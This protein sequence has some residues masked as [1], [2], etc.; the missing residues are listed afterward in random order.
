MDNN[1]V[2]IEA[3]L[4][5]IPFL[6]TPY[7]INANTVS[8]TMSSGGRLVQLQ[9]IYLA[10]CSMSQGAYVS[11][12][13]TV[14]RVRAPTAFRPGV[15]LH[16]PW[17]HQRLVPAASHR[18]PYVVYRNAPQRYTVKHYGPATTRN[19]FAA[20]WKS[21]ARLPSLSPAQSYEFVRSA[22]AP[23]SVHSDGGTGAIHT[24]PAP[25]LSLS[26]KPIV[27]IDSDNYHKPTTE[28]AKPTY[29]VTEKYLEQPMYDMS[30]KIEIPVGFSKPT[31]LSPSDIQTLVK[32]GPA[33][34]FAH[35]Y[36]LSVALPSPIA[37][38]QFSLQGFH[39]LPAHQEIMNPSLD[40]L[41][42]SPS[43]LY[44]ADPAF[45][46]KL[47]TQL[48]QRFP[49]LGFIPYAPDAP[50]ISLQ[51]HTEPQIQ[52]PV[53]NPYFLL[54][55]EE[56]TKRTPA[57]FEPPKNVVQRETHESSVMSLIPHSFT[58]NNVTENQIEVTSASEPQNVTVEVIAADSQ[59]STTTVKYIVESTTRQEPQQNVTPIYYAQIGQSIGNA[60]AN[61]FYSAIND[62]RAAAALAQVDKPQEQDNVTSTTLNPEYKTFIIKQPDNSNNQSIELKPT[63]LGLP[64]SK[65][66]DSVNIAY[67]LL[68]SNNKEP[69]LSKEGAVYGGQI[70]EATISEDKEYNKEKATLLT[71]RAPLRI[72]SVTEKKEGPSIST[73]PPKITVVKAKIPPK[74]KLTFDDKTGE[75]VLRIYASYVDTPS[76]KEIVTSKL[77]HVNNQN[78]VKEIVVKKPDT[79]ENWTSAMVKKFDKTQGHDANQVTDFGLKLRSRSD[80]YIPIF[81]E[82]EE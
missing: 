32:N 19:I 57:L 14:N 72:I 12:M 55:N 25:N 41:M 5:S 45:M 78:K 66:S 54:E 3:M 28:A 49:S 26:E 9:L 27:V 64:F 48:I 80:D 62:V 22:S 43:S 42:I 15:T 76:Q 61:S 51:S 6:H 17:M 38:Q 8:N 56:I 44:Q 68:R 39:N 13:A 47:Q 23:A 82:Y 35:E 60:V 77:N 67:T 75:P 37:P 18:V 4:H 40:G 31:S 29:E 11:R 36:G 7:D 16:R 46:Q 70:V 58:I 30:P 65:A 1:S 59:P 20:P 33:L 81:E 50:T 53:Q 63:M 2:Y 71:R 52:H 34:Q 79:I 69:K 24:I 73:V 21:T 10:L 74:S